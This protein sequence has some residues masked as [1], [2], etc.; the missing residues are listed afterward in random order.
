MADIALQIKTM[1]QKIAKIERSTYQK[2]NI[3]SQAEMYARHYDQNEKHIRQQIKRE[4][5]ALNKTKIKHK[6]AEETLQKV[7]VDVEG[8]R[9]Q[10]RIAGKKRKIIKLGKEV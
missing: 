1:E 4:Q 7:Q 8:I 9:K 3:I 10:N 5:A 6:E 2:T